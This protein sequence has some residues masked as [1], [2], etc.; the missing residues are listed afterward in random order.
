MQNKIFVGVTISLFFLCLVV[1]GAF[2]LT[3]DISV[4]QDV[5]LSGRNRDGNLNGSVIQ[6]L[7]VGKNSRHA[8]SESMFGFDVSSIISQVG[9]DE[10][11]QINS[12]TFNAYHNYNGYD[13]WVDVGLGNTDDWD[14][15]IVTHNTSYY[16]HGPT[17][18]STYLDDNNVNQYVSWDISAID[19]SIL[20]DNFLTLY[21]FTTGYG[22]NWHDFEHGVWSGDNEAYLSIDYDIVPKLAPV[23]VPVPAAVPEPTTMLLLGTGLAGLAAVRRRR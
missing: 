11:L 1:N 20:M 3:V 13:G 12:L 19:E 23:P 10:I 21:L 18:Q 15:D 17:L 5:S 2:A 22:Y 14:A 16:D 7:Y 9:S 4:Y 8:R 6:Y